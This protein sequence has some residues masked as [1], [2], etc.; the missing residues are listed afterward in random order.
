M[1]PSDSLRSLKGPVPLLQPLSRED[2]RPPLPGDLAPCCRLQWCAC[3]DRRVWI[4]VEQCR[5]RQP[6]AASCFCQAHQLERTLFTFLS[7]WEKKESYVVTWKPRESHI[8]GLGKYFFKPATHPSFTCR[9]QLLF[10][11]GTAGLKSSDR[12][13]PLAS[14][15]ENTCSLVLYRKV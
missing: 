8:S 5:A 9:L 3:R 12:P 1:S 6:A 15:A 14:R 4:S 10:L 11:S 13:D 7:D 2:S